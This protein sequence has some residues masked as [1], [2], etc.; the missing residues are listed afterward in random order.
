MTDTDQHEDNVAHTLPKLLRRLADDGGEDGLNIGEIRD[1]L[2]E[3]AYGLLI[4]ILCIPCLVPG[5]YGVP[6]VAG[7]IIIVLAAQLLIG[8]EEP[9]LPG[10]ML[11]LHVKGKWLS[12]MAEFAEKRL[13][14]V[15]RLS[16]PRLHALVVGPGERI[17]AI[18]TILATLTIVL[19]MTNTIPSLAVTLL[20]AG[21]IQRDGVFV[22]GGSLIAT[23]W[24]S[25]VAAV[26]VGL[27]LGAGWATRLIP[28]A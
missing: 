26:G 10:W 13:D 25:L 19:P 6:Q 24:V 3:R 4:L 1:R 12:A 2:D 21:L 8:K 17:A 11:R 7:L 16:R 23:V 14:W 9:W 15:S 20:A 18:F 28:G 5:L 27:L 22:L